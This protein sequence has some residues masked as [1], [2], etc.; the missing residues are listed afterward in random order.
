MKRLRRFE[1]CWTEGKPDRPHL[2]NTS[3]ESGMVEEV[4]V[5]GQNGKPDKFRPYIIHEAYK[6][7][8][9]PW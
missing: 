2:S 1:C 5:A 9:A 4:K 3:L 7:F 8:K 6:Y